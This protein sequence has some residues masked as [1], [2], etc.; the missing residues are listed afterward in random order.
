MFFFE[1]I[2][3]KRYCMP[4]LSISHGE[5]SFVPSNRF[6]YMPAISIL[7]VNFTLAQPG[8]FCSKSQNGSES[9]EVMDLCIQQ[10]IMIPIIEKQ[11]RHPRENL[12][13]LI[14]F[15]LPSRSDQ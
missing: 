15:P 2:D 11:V 9:E 5:F 8:I 12:E 14:A 6:P 3:G 13:P 10:L 4:P 7:Q 1:I